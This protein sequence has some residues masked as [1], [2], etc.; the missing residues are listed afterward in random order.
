M[1]AMTCGA[2]CGRGVVVTGAM[3]DPYNL[4]EK[5]T[6][7]TRHALTLLY[8][9]GFGVAIDTKSPLVARDADLLSDMHRQAPVIVKI[10]VTTA[11]DDLCRKIEHNVVVSSARFEVL[12]TLSA[13]G[14]FSGVLLMPPVAL[15]QQ[16]GR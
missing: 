8:A 14:I 12:A 3:S 16:H 5:E 7:L 4:W 1:C 11:Q 6:Q 9:Y 10:S 13:Q 2:K 15:Y